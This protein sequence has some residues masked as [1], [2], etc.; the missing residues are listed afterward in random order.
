MAKK[1]QETETGEVQRQSRKEYL[2][3]Q[4]EAAQ[5]RQVYR[6]LGGVLVLLLLII[7]FALVN[8]FVLAPN[9]PVATINGEEISLQDWENRVRYERA[10]RIIVL[11]NQ[12]EAFNG[13]VGLIQQFAGQQINELYLPEELGQTV[14]DLMVNEAVIRQAAEERGISVTE[15]EVDAFIGE[16]FNFY[17]GESPTPLPTPTETVMPTPSLTPIPTAVI[18]EVLP[19]ALPLPSPTVGPTSTPPPT[20][21]P[22][23]RESFEQEFNDL[24]AQFA[25]Y[26]VDEATY[27]SVVRSQIY[28]DKLTDAL[29]EESNL[30]DEAEQASLYLLSFGTEEEANEAVDQIGADGFLTVWNTI[31]SATRE[32]ESTSTANAFELLW[33]R[34]EDFANFGEE[35]QAAA[36]NLPLGTPSDVLVQRDEATETETYYIVQVSGREVRPLSANAL[37]TE[38]REN[39]TSFLDTQIAGNLEITEFWRNRVPTQPVLDPKFLVA[40]TPAPAEATPGV[41]SP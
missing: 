26:G 33:R 37:E 13:D 40:P 9:R 25:E 23:S 28:I 8:E 27:R 31:R 7:V 16:G 22:V 24:L 32:P 4:R 35:V 12:Y 3:A 36:F 21:T 6:A 18:T 20:A 15:S 19:T 11:E 1:R 34:P 30:P 2:R 29:A 39:L 10:Q 38:K 14:I 41:L 5:K 17:D